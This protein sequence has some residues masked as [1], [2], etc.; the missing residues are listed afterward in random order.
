MGF[1][2]FS[3]FSMKPLI[4]MHLLKNHKEKTENFKCNTWVTKGM[5]KSV[6]ITDRL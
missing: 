2:T 6:S 3:D 5:R 4:G 1:E